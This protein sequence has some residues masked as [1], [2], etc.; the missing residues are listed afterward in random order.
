MRP[1][2]CRSVMVFAKCLVRQH[3]LTTSSIT[4]ISR[5]REPPTST[6]C[7]SKPLIFAFSLMA[8]MTA[9]S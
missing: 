3:S 6:F 7:T 8:F 4:H 9:L 1:C 2:R 5:K